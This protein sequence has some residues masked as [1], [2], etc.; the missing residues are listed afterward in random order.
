MPQSNQISPIK[1]MDPFTF[2]LVVTVAALAIIVVLMLGILDIANLGRL[3]GPSS[4][5]PEDQQ[6]RDLKVL[7]D[8]DE[9]VG[10]EADLNVT[11]LDTLDQ[12]LDQALVESGEY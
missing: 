5:V 7:N 10:I 4:Q 2:L 9:V 3:T 12:E 11:N 6:I 8:S 1:R